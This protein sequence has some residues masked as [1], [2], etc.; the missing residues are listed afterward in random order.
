VLCASCG[1]ENRAGRK[2]CVHCGAGLEFS[3][4]SCGA[5]TDPG[6]RF[7]GECGRSIS[8]PPKATLVLAP[9][10]ETPNH[11][12]QK[13]LS[14]RSAL[15]G[16]RKTI[17]AL[18]ADIKGSMELIEGVDPE[19]ARRIVDPALQLMIDAVHRYEGYVAQ[20]TGDGIFA[21]FGA[22]IAHEDHAQRAVYAALRMQEEIKKYADEL[23]RE[24]GVVIEA[25]VGLNTG[26]VVVRSIRKDD[27]HT[28]YV[29]IG[30]STSL[31]A[32]MESLATPG[33]IVVSE[34]TQKL[35]D[36]YFQF[37][38]FGPVQVKGVSEPVSV[39]EV[40]GIGPLRTKLEVAAKRGLARFVGR[41]SELEQ[42]QRALALVKSGH[43]Q[44]AAVVG[45]PGVGKSR[46]LHEFKLASHSGCLVLEAFAV[47]YGRVY[48]YLPL[49]DLLNGYFGIVRED[50]E[51]QRRDKVIDKVLALDRS[52][53]ESLPYLYLFALLGIAETP[54]ALAQMD[55][56]I[57][58][59]R[60]LETIKRLLVRESMNQP[61]ILVL[62]DLHWIDHETQAFLDEL[63]DSM[64]G[65]RLLLLVDYRPEHRHAWASK[66]Y[67][68]QIRLD[69]LP[70]ESAQELLT[71]LLGDAPELDGLKRLIIAKSEGTPF[72]IEEIVQALSERGI[73][74]R[75]NGVVRLTAP[76]AEIQIPA[77][78]QGMLVARIDRLDPEEKELLQTAAVM[79]R[80]FSQ[81]LLARVAGLSEDDVRP[82]LDRLQAV[83]LVYERLSHPDVM[84]IFKHALTQEVAYGSLLIE[85]RKELHERTARQIEALFESRLEDHYGDLAHHYSCSTN[86]QK[87]V[88]YL[89]LTAQQA[90][91]RSAHAEA[92]NHLTGALE[93]LRALPD[94][95]QRAQ[96]EL[97]LQM[98]LGP[99]LIAT[100]G[101]G[102]VEVGAVY[103]RALELGRQVGQDAQLFPVLFG[104]RSFHLI[105][106]E[107][108]PAFD[109]AQQLTS[110]A[111][112]AQDSGLLVEA[113]LA[114]GNSLFLF[115]QFIPA[116]VHIERAIAVYDPQKHHVHAFLYGL[117]PGVFCL[118]KSA[119]LLALLGRLDQA[120]KKV[121]EALAL[122]HQQS[123]A[124]S[125][126][127]ALMNVPPVHEF[128]GEWAAMQQAQEAAIAICAERG[129]A[130]ILAQATMHRGHA[131][132]Q[133]GQIEEGIGLMRG[134]LAAQL[135]TGAVLFRPIFLCYLAKAYG[136]AGRFE[137]GL[138]TV[139]EAITIMEKTDERLCE[140]ELYRLKGEFVLG[141]SGVETEPEVQTEAEECLRKAIEI[142]RRQEAKY[143][144]LKAVMSLSRLWQQQG[145]KDEARRMLA[146]I[147]GW[148]SEGFD[149]KDLNDAKAL[150]DQLS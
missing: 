57:R 79:G 76:L 7:C 75:G 119:W 108:H 8:G 124:F 74:V 10:L 19:E 135:A 82:L 16:E 40:T 126:A 71:A 122:A 47:S 88:E 61:I 100:R 91:Q 46:L 105:R 120:S 85:R 58:R 43:G 109:L 45:E 59:R 94:T 149:T 23:R 111:E 84:Y 3:C 139:A 29:P 12:A 143:L 117:D 140:A 63:V 27:L 80:D 35:V 134:G 28:D 11:L 72:F 18:F 6:E 147:Y 116:L 60:T 127:V 67:Y 123:H 62:E 141:R 145:K 103:K 96:Q 78:V 48:P 137:E 102:A 42:I 56:K 131:L 38:A 107:L 125:L 129:F 95:P 15:E 50:A 64:A 115:G 133:Q 55:P 66:T 101:N 69:P 89:Q 77:T 146:E 21:L 51:P 83:E 4:P 70:E 9:R 97:A 86:R 31:A 17:T 41:K 104:L 39:Y 110:L 138:A 53:E 90:V 87:A 99:A 92:I 121:G 93:I 106:G 14:S 32:R 13:I 81:N 26:E 44:I 30:H 65:V 33:S 22:P 112:S 128:R 20:S 49:I 132:A 148:F 68:N 37:R 142:A 144:E 25:R 36:G 130:S 114:Q 2:F 34:H 73:L 1:H 150:I 24:K 54:S 136:T 118:A 5:S 113:H 98:M 52:L